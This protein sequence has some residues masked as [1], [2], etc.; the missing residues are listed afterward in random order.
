M[1]YEELKSFLAKDAAYCLELD[2]I[3]SI[4]SH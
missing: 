1:M 2:K 3:Q 4:D